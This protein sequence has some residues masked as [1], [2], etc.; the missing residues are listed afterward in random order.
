MGSLKLD[1][2]SIAQRAR[3][4]G[5]VRPVPSMG[6][7]IARGLI[8]FTLVSAAGVAASA[9]VGRALG[10]YIGEVGLYVVCAVVFIVLS[11]L[12]LH[13]LII[14]AGTLPRFCK[15]F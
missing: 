13:R 15:L 8:G 4:A 5:A 1:P 9:V 12:F 11:G 7:S 10:R 3:A 2:A 14:G 6:E